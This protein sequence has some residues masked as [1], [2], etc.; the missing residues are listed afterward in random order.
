MG[1]RKSRYSNKNAAK[2]ISPADD[3]C[4]SMRVGHNSR[5]FYLNLMGEGELADIQVTLEFCYV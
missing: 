2:N 4:V 1:T 5:L 3:V